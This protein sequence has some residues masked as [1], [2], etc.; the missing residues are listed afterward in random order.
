MVPA[1]FPTASLPSSDGL[2]VPVGRGATDG[3]CKGEGQ[4][5]EYK[6]IGELL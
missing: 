2:A 5:T 4:G 1:V 6:T 3:T